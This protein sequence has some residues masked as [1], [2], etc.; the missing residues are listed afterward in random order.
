MGKIKS[1]YEAPSDS[2]SNDANNEPVL[3]ASADE[4]SEDKDAR[5]RAK[6]NYKTQMQYQGSYP[7]EAQELKEDYERKV[8]KIKSKY[9]APVDSTSNDQSN[10]PLLLASAD[11]SGEEKDA[12]R[13]AKQN[14]KTQMQYQGFYPKEAQELKQEYERKVAKIKSKYEAPADSSSDDAN[15][16]PVFWASVEEGGEEEDALR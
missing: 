1:K 6:Q 3:L 9:A 12:L 13:R 2:S 14:Y 10:E 11:E 15:N 8:A 5:R 4:S 7:K 16:E